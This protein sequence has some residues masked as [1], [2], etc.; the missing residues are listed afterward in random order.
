MDPLLKMLKKKYVNGRKF[1]FAVEFFL[2]YKQI[3]IPKIEITKEP[4]KGEIDFLRR[5]DKNNE[6][7][8]IEK[9]IKIG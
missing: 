9:I 5:L 7:E 8:K 3:L 2:L 6:L 1:L 4:T